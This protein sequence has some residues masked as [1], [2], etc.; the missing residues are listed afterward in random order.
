MVLEG[1]G[2]QVKVGQAGEGPGEIFIRDRS[3]EIL[4]SAPLFSSG[5]KGPSRLIQR[6]RFIHLSNDGK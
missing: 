1:E 6:F 3:Q 4:L 2:E 5:G